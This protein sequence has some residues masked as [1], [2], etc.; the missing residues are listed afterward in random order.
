[1][2]PTT[3][4][5]WFLLLE[6]FMGYGTTWYHS[7]EDLKLYHR[8]SAARKYWAKAPHGDMKVL[9][10]HKLSQRLAVDNTMK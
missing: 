5:M 8:M 3:I 9:K 6:Q 10:L 2:Q 7:T 1:M 4:F